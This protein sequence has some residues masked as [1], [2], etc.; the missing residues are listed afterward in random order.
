MAAAGRAR[1]LLAAL[2]LLL[3]SALAQERA[4]AA[5]ALEESGKRDEIPATPRNDDANPDDDPAVWE[6]TGCKKFCVSEPCGEFN[7]NLTAECGGCGESAVCRPGAAG[8]DSWQERRQANATIVALD[9]A[10]KA[11]E[12]RVEL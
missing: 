10:R 3:A 6:S 4:A 2:C 12:Q 1:A 8:F 5:A 7:G 11:R 9:A